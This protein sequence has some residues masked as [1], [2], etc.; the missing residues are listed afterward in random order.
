MLLGGLNRKEKAIVMKLDY[1][2][3]L[4]TLQRAGSVNK[5]AQL[6]HTSAQNVSRVLRQLE[7]ELGCTLFIRTPYGLEITEAGREAIR[8]AEDILKRIEAFKERFGQAPAEEGYAGKM[9]V[10]V[11]KIESVRFM[12]EAVMR[13]SKRHPQVKLSYV[14]DDFGACLALLRQTADSVGVL[15]ILD[16]PQEGG[17]GGAYTDDFIWRPLDRDQV[18]IIVGKQSKLYQYKTVT[19]NLLKGGRFAIYAKNDFEDGFWSRIIQQHI[20]QPA[21]IFVASN[22]YI[23]Y[24]KII[25]EGYIGLGCQKSSPHSDTLHNQAMREQVGFI[26][27]RQQAMFHNCIVLPGQSV[28]SAVIKSFVAFLETEYGGGSQGG[29]EN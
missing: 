23:L 27:I 26:P 9:T 15:P 13:F 17:I 16:E 1:L 2:L 12:N 5:S 10:A 24:S 22:G 4:E 11:T 25:N 6:L 3:Y 28:N 29:S 21:E 19:Y 18:C 20:R 8:M 14:E 7:T